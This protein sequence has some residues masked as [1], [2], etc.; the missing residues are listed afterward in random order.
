MPRM[1]GVIPRY[2]PHIP[3]RWMVDERTYPIPCLPDDD[4]LAAAVVE[5]VV[6]VVVAAAALTSLLGSSIGFF[7]FFFRNTA[8]CARAKSNGY[9]HNTDIVPAIIPDIKLSTG[10]NPAPLPN[11]SRLR[12]CCCCCL[13]LFLLFRCGSVA[14]RAMVPR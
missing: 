6:V 12:C 8:N 2:N 5:A 9:V 13:L 1:V 10:V 14:S 7:F 3:L 11:S 4:C